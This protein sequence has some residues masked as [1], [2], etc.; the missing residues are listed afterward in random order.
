M[1]ATRMSQAGYGKARD[2]SRQRV[3]QLVKD[4]RVPLDEDGQVMVEQ[5][6][7]NLATMLDQRRANR[8]RQVAIAG[9]GQVTTLRSAQAD[10]LLLEER[11]ADSPPAEADKP[12]EKTKAPN[13][14]TD[15]WE[16]KA[17]RERIEADRAELAY[18][19]SVQDAVSADDVERGEHER[20]QKLANSLL[21][22]P[23][24]IAPVVSPHD[25]QRAEL[26]MTEEIKKAI[27][28]LAGELD[29]LAAGDDAERP[30]AGTP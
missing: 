25:P 10:E 5:A 27:N 13:A 15:Y 21:Q 28:G 26:L 3:G 19:K 11:P 7:I 9:A 1:N 8:A 14:A 23:A 18:R 29:Q 2:L 16:Q 22:I 4:G 24:R 30:A 6:D 12:S 17:R 20:G